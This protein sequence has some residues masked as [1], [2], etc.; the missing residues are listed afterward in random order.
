MNIQPR[1]N[2]SITKEINFEL[3]KYTIFAG[4]NN[5]GKTNLIKAMKDVLPPEQT[6]YIPAESIK[7]GE[8]VKTTATEDPMR[9]AF[10]KL[11]DITIGQLP[12]V[13]YETVKNFLD[14]I[15]NTFDSFKVP[16]VSLELGVKKLTENDVKK[17]IKDE[18]SKK[19][20]DSVVKDKY[21][22]G[23]DLKIEEVGQGTQR[24]IITAILQELGKA[25][26]QNQELF[27]L[28]EEPEIYLHPKLKRSLHDA[29]LAISKNNI[30]VILTTHDPYF[31]ELVADQIIYTVSRDND[32]S[33]V[34][35]VPSLSSVLNDSTYAEINYVIFDV[36][37]TDY[38]LQ[39]FHQAQ[40]KKLDFKD[41]KIDGFSIS[42]I[43]TSLAHKPGLV[44]RNSGGSSPVITEDLKKNTIDYIRNI[45]KS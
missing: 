44:D 28:F 26:T 30:R 29:L 45:L 2:S 15:S 16:N 3:G 13:N 37:S 27:L 10:L 40:D 1:D 7:A 21:G 35:S 42:D 5:A 17:I 20:L 25:N 22:V 12:I 43:R 11:I 9:R 18:V 38:L 6:I 4:E 32:G 33:T 34:V 39:L 8:H 19:I 24:L 36:P 23:C 41:H 31:I 14:E